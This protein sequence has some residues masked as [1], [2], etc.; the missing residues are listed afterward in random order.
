MCGFADSSWKEISGPFTCTFGSC[1][2]YTKRMGFLPALHR[3]LPCY[4][5]TTVCRKTCSLLWVLVHRLANCRLCPLLPWVILRTV[6]FPGLEFHR[7]MKLTGYKYYRLLLVSADRGKAHGSLKTNTCGSCLLH[8]CSWQRYWWHLGTAADWR[9]GHYFY[10]QHFL[11]ANKGSSAH[12]RVSEPSG[13]HP[14]HS[15]SSFLQGPSCSSLV[16]QMVKSLPEVWETQVQS[17]GQEDPLE[18]EVETHSSILAWKI[19]WTEEPGTLQYMGSQRVGHDWTTSLS[20][21]C[22]LF[23]LWTELGKSHFILLLSWIF[24]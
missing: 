7:K 8:L 13:C 22:L 10:H 12:H 14:A 3:L 1:Y 16:A 19:P 2:L 17:L 20:F 18:K 11:I 21:L 6:C 5:N 4:S 9:R 15:L 24:F 23:W